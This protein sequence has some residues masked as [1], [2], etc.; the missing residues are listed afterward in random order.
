MTMPTNRYVLPE[1]V[2]RTPE[3][4]RVS[5]PYSRLFEDRIIFVGT[6][7]DDTTS[8]DVI[9]QL[10]YLEMKDN[11]RTISIY[12]NSAGGY[13]SS[14]SAII[15]TMDFIE[16]PVA[17]TIIGEAGGAS[18]LVAMSAQSRLILPNAKILLKQPGMGSMQGK[19][20]DLGIQAKEL[21]ALR[22]FVSSTIAKH[23]TLTQQEADIRIEHQLILTA[24][25][26]LDMGLVDEVISPR[27]KK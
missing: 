10:L 12:I 26:A 2:E 16:S 8:N 24:Q 4:T 17:T 3:G 20:S 21:E 9:A 6:P 14:A 13:M 11:T 23:S 25:E 27:K 1:L 22:E 19:E 7:L 15:D 5:D 18:A